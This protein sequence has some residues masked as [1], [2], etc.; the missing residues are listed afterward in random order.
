MTTC[1]RL[2]LWFSLIIFGLGV[3]TLWGTQMHVPEENPEYPFLLAMETRGLLDSPL[4]A[5]RP[6][7]KSDVA[8]HLKTLLKK[9]GRLSGTE[10]EIL[11]MLVNRYRPELSDLKHPRLAEE[12]SVHAFP[13]HIREDLQRKVSRSI[14]SE[15]DYLF[16]FETEDEYLFLQG[17][18]LLRLE[19]KNELFR[20]SGHVGFRGF[21]QMGNVSVFGEAMAYGQTFKDG[22]MEDPVESRRYYTHTDSVLSLAT[23]DNAMG[24]IQL[25]TKAGLFTLGNDFLSW[26]YG[27][28]SMTLSGETAPFPYMMWQKYFY[29]SRF[30]FFHGSLLNAKYTLSED[31]HS[32]IYPEKYIAGHRL[33][34]YPR[35]NLSF[36]FSEFVVYGL[37]N[38]EWTYF[39]PAAFIWSAE[40]NL[41]DRDNVLMS[42]EAQ[43]QPVR[44]IKIHG[45]FFLDELDF[46]ELG[47]QWWGNKHGTQIGLNISLPVISGGEFFFERS[48][49]RPWTYTHY[50]DV[51]TFTHKGDCLGFFAGPN[52]RVYTLGVR[53]WLTS[54]QSF[55]FSFQSVE[56]G[57]E[58]LPE[59]HPDYYPIG[60][61]AN[62][63]Y[64]QRNKGYDYKTENLMGDVEKIMSLHV[65]WQYQMLNN[66]WLNIS[67]QPQWNEGDMTHY[68]RLEWQV[69]H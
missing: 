50:K 22:F 60:S 53:G 45:N 31:G 20:F 69:K 25:N 18:G 59:S 37:R 6:W 51:N 5:T 28:N 7:I 61:D 56:K 14:I 63:N 32:R 52:S 17:D 43:W 39:I 9:T 48:Q 2:G 65:E 67:W 30:T 1:C 21:A 10:R 35:K 8:E 24:Y 26:G 16:L 38:M 41:D 13:L 40:H 54:A 49:V 68:G 15:P 47:T 23:F 46:R 3:Q 64:Y 19:N 34:M 55:I 12:D 36:A 66:M 58:L 29:R 4:P 62:Q 42:F 44:G 11:Q 27:E 57:K 33:E